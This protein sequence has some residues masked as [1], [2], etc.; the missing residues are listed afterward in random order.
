MIKKIALVVGGIL[1]AGVA[2]VLCLALTKPD[3]FVVER[4][5][6]IK[7][8]AEEIFAVIGDFHRSP[9][10]S[11]WEKLD[12]N[13]KRTYSGSASGKGAV[14]SWTGNDQVGEGSMEILEFNPPSKMVMNLHFVKPMA[15]DSVVEY[16]LE[17]QGDSTKMTWL[18]HGPN[19]FMGKV[20]QVFMN[21]QDSCGK[22]FED[23]L[24]NLKAVCEK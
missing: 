1:L 16:T 15:G 12:P 19:D 2:I 22:A 13:M 10:W 17:P 5:T 6:V 23:G 9:E 3:Q 20:M 24:A 11:P 8:P 21:C 4:S 14:Y 7:A 18:M